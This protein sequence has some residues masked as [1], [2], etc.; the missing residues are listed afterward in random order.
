MCV[1]LC[2]VKYII[3]KETQRLHHN[4]EPQLV[5]LPVHRYSAFK[6]DNMILVFLA[7]KPCF[8]NSEILLQ[9]VFR[10][11]TR[12]S[13]WNPEAESRETLPKVKKACLEHFWQMTLP[14]CSWSLLQFITLKL[15][16]FQYICG[17]PKYLSTII[18]YTFQLVWKPEH[19]LN[20]N[21]LQMTPCLFTTSTFQYTHDMKYRSK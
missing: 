1:Y 5:S 7:G 14:I 11:T 20:S 16:I 18:L 4:Y 3:W 10:A 12:C 15:N 6:I 2:M 8:E 13:R 19:I 17:F 9:W 21:P